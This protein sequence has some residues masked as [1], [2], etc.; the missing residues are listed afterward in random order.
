MSFI[1][2]FVTDRHRWIGK[3]VAENYQHIC[4]LYDIR[5][6]A[7]CEHN[8]MQGNFLKYKPL[9]KIVIVFLFPTLLLLVLYCYKEA[10][11]NL[12]TNKMS[13]QVE[14]QR[15]VINHLY[16]AVISTASREGELIVEK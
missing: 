10:E 13:R 15:S 6:V 16:W 8:K 7:K 4:H 14:W 1:E 12:P 9:Y 11:D 3:W 2:V 5:R